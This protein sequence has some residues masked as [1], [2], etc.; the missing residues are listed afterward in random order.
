MTVATWLG[1]AA[2]GGAGA[3][4]RVLVTTAAARSR[5]G[6]PTGTLAVN[7]V[8]AFAFG[9]LT[10]QGVD[11][12]ALLLAGTALAGSLSTFSTLMLEAHELGRRR[13]LGYLALSLLLGLA[14]AGVG[15]SLG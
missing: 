11:G 2:L 12:E 9:L 1:V 8:A 10:G 5:A 4:A 6:A 3:V 7:V 13:G 15:R 14:A